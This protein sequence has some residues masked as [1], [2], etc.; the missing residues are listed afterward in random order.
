M[1]WIISDTSSRHQTISV[2]IISGREKPRR[3]SR[4][5]DARLTE[6]REQVIVGGNIRSVA[7]DGRYKHP[8]EGYMNNNY[9]SAAL[10]VRKTH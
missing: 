7:R 5:D 6:N 3:K 4:A 10:L 1:I 8:N 2:F 9:N